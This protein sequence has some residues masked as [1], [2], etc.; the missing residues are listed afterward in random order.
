MSWWF[1]SADF[2]AIEGGRFD[3]APPMGTCYLATRPEAAVLEALQ[4]S[5]TNLP[6]SELT[7]RRLATLTAPE[8]APAAAML[9]ARR[10]A[11]EFGITAELWAGRNRALTRA[12]AA[13]LRRDGWWAVYGGVSHDPSGR[14]RSVAL[15]DV[16]GAH[17]PTHGERW[18][19]RSRPIDRD[20]TLERALKRYG[21]TI[22]D[23]GQLPWKSPP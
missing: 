8:D 16:A 5:L 7:V 19:V 2:D 10:V 4:V 23:P 18:Q 12:W 1:A 20:A 3:L 15:F 11:G 21:V 13:A 6:R 17:P 14:L 9:T 22:R